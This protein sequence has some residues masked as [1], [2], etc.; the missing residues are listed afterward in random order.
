M[1]IP[2]IN[3]LYTRIRWLNRR[4]FQLW[5]PW[6]TLI[7]FLLPARDTV[8]E[9]DAT[10]N[11]TIQIRLYYFLPFKPSSLEPTRDNPIAKL[12]AGPASQ[13]D[14]E[15]RRHTQIGRAI[16]S[17]DPVLTARF[18]KRFFILFCE[19]WVN[20]SIHEC[21]CLGWVPRLHPATAKSRDP[22]IWSPWHYY[23]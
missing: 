3:K 23:V 7:S 10:L 8:D 15:D 5:Q 21:R 11:S 17:Y 13:N 12:C 9:A 14:H 20:F 22:A 16:L 18:G 19:S 1:D 4:L 2:H 6:S